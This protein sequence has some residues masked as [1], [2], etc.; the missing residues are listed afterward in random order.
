[1]PNPNYLFSIG[2]SAAV[3]TAAA[4]ATCLI[5]FYFV[6]L[7]GQKVETAPVATP[8]QS[9]ISTPIQEI[10]N[11]EIKAADVKSVTIDTVYKGFFE[12]RNKCAKTYN[13]YFGNDDGIYSSSSP[14]NIRMSFDREGH[15]ARSIVI[16]RWDKTAKEK[17]VIEKSDS[18]IWSMHMSLLSLMR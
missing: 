5:F 8:T 9:P 4:L 18:T 10:P 7:P 15:S 12:P 6:Y 1:M 3:G 16:S 14:C 2:I 17:H 11:P 13:E